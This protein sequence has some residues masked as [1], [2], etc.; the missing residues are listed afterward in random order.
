MFSFE[1]NNNRL[2]I[3]ILLLLY[4]FL[5]KTVKFFITEYDLKKLLF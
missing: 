2:I 5:I 4:F 3:I 1:I